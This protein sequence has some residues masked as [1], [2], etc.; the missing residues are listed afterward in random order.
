[1]HW[2]GCPRPFPRKSARWDEQAG[3]LGNIGPFPPYPFHRCSRKSLVLPQG[4]AC[5]FA[6]IP[7]DKPRYLAYRPTAAATNAR[8]APFSAL[9]NVG[10][11]VTVSFLIARFHVPTTPPRTT[12]TGLRMPPPALTRLA[13]LGS[14]ISLR[15]R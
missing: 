6:R 3:P 1:M 11:T 15:S 12:I 4:P 2:I 10:V 13:Y 5:Y 7:S 9:K 8:S 14:R